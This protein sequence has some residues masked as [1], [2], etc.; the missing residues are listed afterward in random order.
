M[1]DGGCRYVDGERR[2]GRVNVHGW[3]DLRSK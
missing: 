2:E 3:K 1:C